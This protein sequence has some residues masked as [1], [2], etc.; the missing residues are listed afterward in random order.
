MIAGPGLKL[1]GGIFIDTV[2]HQKLVFIDIGHFFEAAE[3]FGH[4]K[5]GEKLVQIKRVHEQL[6][7]GLEFGL[8]ARA[9]FGFGHDVDVQPG[10]LGRKSHVL[11]ATA[12]GQRKLFFGHHHFDPFGFFIQNHFADLGGLQRVHQKRRRV[13]IP[14]NDVNLLTLQ[15]VD[16]RLHPAAA[17]PHAGAH[18]VDRTVVTDHRD[19]GAAAGVTRDSLDLDDAV[20]NLRHFHLEQLGHE[21]GRCA[22]QENLRSA[23]FAPH[24]LDVTADAVVRA[25]A[26][27]ADLLVAPEYRLAPAH[28]DDDVAVFLA[29]DD[30]VDDRASPVLEFLELLVA[31]S[32]A[33]PLQD[34]LFGRL[35]GNSAH[36]NRRHLFDEL[37]TDLGVFHIL[38]G[39]FDGELSLI[40]LKLFFLDDRANTGKRRAPRLAVNR[41][42]NIHLGPVP[43]LGG[44]GEA[45]FHRFD[46]QFGVDHFFARNRIGGL[47]QFQLV[48]ACYGHRSGLLAVDDCLD[49]VELGFVYIATGFAGAQHVADQVVGQHQLGLGK[50]LKLQANR[51][52]LDLDQNFAALRT[53]QIAPEPFAPVD[54]I[55]CFQLGNIARPGVEIL[56]PGQGPVDAG[57]G[58][59]ERVIV[60]NRVLDVQRGRDRRRD[61]RAVV[62][63][64]PAMRFVGHD[65][66][67]RAVAA[68]Q[69]DAHQFEAE[70]FDHGRHEGGQPLVDLGLGDQ[71]VH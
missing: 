63:F 58:N 1:V 50:P 24:V 25:I 17:H 3:P 23:H 6:G 60:V 21:F 19:L 45:F 59:L 67:R 34:H 40:I 55:G 38:L 2:D 13:V 12:D 66:Q 11:S 10:Q 47:Q 41:H 37:L 62:N 16:Y 65:L 22:A 71:V 42:A 44:T 53:G 61:F 8:T 70:V 54:Q 48:C 57:A 4:Q 35:R 52:F 26:F 69:A 64:D 30:T 7:P 18:G 20:V 15:F 5:L 33:D 49:F 36:F 51:A 46:D 14:W 9:F 32:L 31:L 39:L 43:G 68:H 29:L 28:V 27:A 56:H